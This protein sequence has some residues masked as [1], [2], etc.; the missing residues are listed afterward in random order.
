MASINKHAPAV[1]I[2]LSL[3]NLAGQAF[4]A[5]LPTVAEVL[6]ETPFSG[7]HV[8]QVLKGEIAA[9]RVVPVSKTE[10]AQGVGCLISN[11]TLEKLDA[12]EGRTWLGPEK[13]FL[14][15]GQIPADPVLADFDDVRLYPEYEDEIQEYVDAK[16]GVNLNISLSEIADFNQLETSVSKEKRPIAVE[17]RIRELLLTRH[18][19]Y[20]QQGIHGLVPYARKRGRE[21]QPLEQLKISLQESLGLKTH[22]PA[23]YS[24]LEQY[25]HANAPGIEF[26]EQY[27]WNIWNLDDRPAVG[28]NHRMHISVDDARFIIE[29]GHYVS[30][31]LENIQILVAVIPVQE[32]LLLVYVNRTWTHK[33]AGFF[34]L[35]KK[36]IGYKIMMSEMEHVLQNLNVCGDAS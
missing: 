20:R 15:S 27:F 14:A 9:T 13:L 30:H 28:L 19:V 5:E 10:L 18:Q 3:L 17:Q 35:L 16:A 2:A 1:L 21:V 8:E 4:A 25:P 24:F 29:R 26:S 12:L 36:R 34:S 7:K 31:S 6:I 33:V 23:I 11:A 22:Y 32:G